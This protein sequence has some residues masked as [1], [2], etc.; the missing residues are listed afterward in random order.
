MSVF[1]VLSDLNFLLLFA[2]ECSFV[3]CLF[4]K[5][6]TCEI[7]SIN[8]PWGGGT[9][10]IFVMDCESVCPNCNSSDN[11]FRHHYQHNNHHNDNNDNDNYNE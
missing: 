7:S 3:G 4:D 5:R 8:F 2:Y 6:Q 10:W 1:Y 9:I 11:H